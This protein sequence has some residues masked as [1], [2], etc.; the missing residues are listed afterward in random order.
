[1]P[2]WDII[3]DHL[4]VLAS[5][6]E[7][8]LITTSPKTVELCHAYYPQV[9]VI[10]KEEAE[11]TP[12]YLAD[13]YDTLFVSYR[14]WRAEMHPLFQ[15]YCNKQ[16]RMV[17]CPHGNSD[18]GH[19][20]TEHPAQ[21]I[22]LVYG[23]HMRALLTHSGAMKDIGHTVV[24][25]NYRLP[26]FLKHR[27][28]Y[29]AAARK[30]IFGK[31]DPNKKTIFYAPTWEDKENPSSFYAHC[32][33]L[34][35]ELPETYNLLIKLHPFLFNDRF[36]LTT[37]ILE[38]YRDHP[39]VLFLEEFPPIYPLLALSDIYFGDFSSV[40]YD[41]LAFD[42]PMYFFPM[43]DSF[44]HQCGMMLPEKGIFEYVEKTLSENQAKFSSVRKKIY[45]YAF[46][47]EKTGQAVAL[48]IKSA[49]E[50]SIL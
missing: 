14:F 5:F 21:D 23:E 25:G 44:L 45:S 32:A 37:H 7:I 16:M 26:F 33:A 36:A 19:S 11:L 17:F 41:F 34:I 4:G 24:T 22:S 2:Q 31:L 30:L 40:G 6:L 47:E 50:K 12:Q 29:E 42:R 28:F 27:D 13:N 39:S 3:L 1:M 15:L 18:K 8:P 9:D 49:L 46:G 38:K 48:D 35:E 43:R 10:F 20:F